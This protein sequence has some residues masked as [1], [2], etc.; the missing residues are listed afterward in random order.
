MSAQDGLSS[1]SDIVKRAKYWGHRAVAITDHG[2]VQAFPE[3]ANAGK[4]CGVKII[5]GMEAYLVPGMIKIFS[6]A[7]RIT[8]LMMSLSFLT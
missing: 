7:G 1:A 2:V 5:Y 4:S 3:A 6:N 8:A